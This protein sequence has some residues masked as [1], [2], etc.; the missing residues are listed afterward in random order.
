MDMNKSDKLPAWP[1]RVAML[2]TI[3]WSHL[4][5]FSLLLFSLSFLP[6]PILSLVPFPF[7]PISVLCQSE[8]GYISGAPQWQQN[9]DS[10][11]IFLRLVCKG[12]WQMLSLCGSSA[13]IILNLLCRKDFRVFKRSN[14]NTNLFILKLNQIETER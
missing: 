5:P 6:H 7:L 9:M 8:A 11:S 13:I 1:L 10:Q 4:L 14:H 3:F 2:L 12:L